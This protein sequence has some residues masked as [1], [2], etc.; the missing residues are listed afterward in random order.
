MSLLNSF[1]KY[2]WTPCCLPHF[3]GSG[4]DLEVPCKCKHLNSTPR[5]HIKMLS[6]AVPNC[7]PSSGEVETGFTSPADSANSR[8]V[9]NPVPKSRLTAT[10]EDTEVVLSPPHT[11]WHVS[12][13]TACILIHT[14]IFLSLGAHR[15]MRPSR[16]RGRPVGS[17]SLTGKADIS[18]YCSA[19][20]AS[21]DTEGILV[22]HHYL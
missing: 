3:L 11:P 4:E 2:L 6:M 18:T 5:M 14:Q 21:G 12:T 22:H 10:E 1:Q 20:A 16:I 19:A 15:I 17:L 9:G 7:N 13:Q 8:S